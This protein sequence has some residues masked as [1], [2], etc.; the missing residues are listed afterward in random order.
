V[1]AMNKLFRKQFIVDQELQFKFILAI[2]LIAMAEGIFIGWG[3]LHLFS[4]AASPEKPHIALEFFKTLGFL[5]VT[6]VAG[7]FLLGMHL[8]HKVAG[9]LFRVRKAMDALRK[10]E[11][12][13]VELRQ[14]DLLNNFVKEFNETTDVLK[15]LLS[16]DR[17]IVEDSL[18]QLDL[19]DDIARES[20]KS[21]SLNGDC[22]T[23]R[24]KFILLRT[25]LVAIN[26]HYR[27]KE[28]GEG[29]GQQNDPDS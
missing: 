12:P 24:K 20:A 19:C 10:G 26:S 1:T 5:L 18:N 6:L 17:K 11:L 29:Y 7:N 23:L 8:S 16:R 28:E 2:T 22:E 9:P 27:Q 25:F 3:V 15:K 14:G 13:S 21:G 4:V